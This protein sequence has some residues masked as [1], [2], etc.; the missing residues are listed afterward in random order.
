MNW[1][2]VA[3]GAADILLGLLLMARSA[4]WVTAP[5]RHDLAAWV[6][7]LLGAWTLFVGLSN[8]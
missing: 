8:S 2:D 1:L 7:I 5:A 3:F 6:L 4:G